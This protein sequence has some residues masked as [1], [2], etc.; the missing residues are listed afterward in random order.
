MFKDEISIVLFDEKLESSAP[1]AV[2][3]TSNSSPPF[4][5][6]LVPQAAVAL[7]LID[8][9]FIDNIYFHTPLS[10]QESN[11]S[12]LKDGG[13]AKVPSLLLRLFR[14]EAKK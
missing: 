11:K 9:T 10:L 7:R 12:L 1:A 13:F 8:L 14:R 5:P 6:R 2:P 4:T 3:V